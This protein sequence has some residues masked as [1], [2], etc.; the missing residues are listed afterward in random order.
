MAN[1]VMITSLKGGVGKSTVTAG[2]S[3]A[4]ALLGK[5]VLVLDFD[6]T[7]RSL[8][9]ILGLESKTVFNAF[10]VTNGRCSLKRALVMHEKVDGLY[11]LAA[12]KLESA[13]IATLDFKQLFDEAST[14]SE[15]GKEFDYIIVDTQ[16]KDA[17]IIRKISPY[18]DRALVVSTQSPSSVR[19]AELTGLLLRESGVADTKLVIN[20]FDADGVMRSGRPGLV[21]II[22]S[23]RL[24]LL[25]AVPYDRELELVSEKG[26]G[27]DTMPKSANTRRAFM[28]IAA[29]LNGGQ[30]PLF[31]GLN[32][33]I[34][35]KVLQIKKS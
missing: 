15:D 12:P 31:D 14:F 34:Y 7:V 17:D 10:D 33:G 13:E 26:D 27:I 32:G 24:M 5:R 3:T 1:T 16:A 4:L 23:T 2:I 28:N 30:T 18:C 19:A 20:G 9:L 25:G 21:E 29:R 6:F 11:F 22:D 8:E 35:K